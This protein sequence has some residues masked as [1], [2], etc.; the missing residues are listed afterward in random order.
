MAYIRWKSQDHQDT[1]KQKVLSVN[2]KGYLGLGQT[3]LPPLDVCPEETEVPFASSRSKSP[4]NLRADSRTRPDGYTKA[5]VIEIL[6][7]GL[8]RVDA[9]KDSLSS[10]SS[11]DG[12]LGFG[13]G[14]TN[15]REHQM[16]S[17]ERSTKSVEEIDLDA[18]FYDMDT[19]ML[20]VFMYDDSSVQSKGTVSTS[21]SSVSSMVSTRSRHRGAYYNGSRQNSLLESSQASLGWLESMRQSSSLVFSKRSWSA[22]HGWAES[23]PWDAL[24]DHG[25]DQPNP[26]FD[27][28]KMVRIEI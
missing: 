14:E 9:R 28:V 26:I 24:P 1:R 16:T 19:Y 3:S 25:W 4:S 10:L 5:V 6:R 17:E 8:P 7:E 22:Q 13:D 27:H 20:S 18:D 11:I 15:H 21:S 2:V 23:K 12:L